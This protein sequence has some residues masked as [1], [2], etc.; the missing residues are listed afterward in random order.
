VIGGEV[1]HIFTCLAT[2]P[3]GGHHRQ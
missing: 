3:P 2:Y 1:A